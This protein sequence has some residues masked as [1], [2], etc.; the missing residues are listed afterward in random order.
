V[1]FTDDSAGHVAA[2]AEFGLVAR[3]FVDAETLRRD[4]DREIPGW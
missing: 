4:L 2:A 3:R 1:F